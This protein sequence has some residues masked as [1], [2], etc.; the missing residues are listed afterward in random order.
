M[1]RVSIYWMRRDLRLED[2]T[3]LSKA[4]HS[5]DPVLPLF[6]F[7]QNILEELP[8]DDARITFIHQQLESIQDTLKKKHN[9][10]LLVQYGKPEKIFQAL[11]NEF[12]ITGVFTNRDYEPYAK[13]RDSEIR[14]LLEAKK[15]P[16]YDFKD[17]VIFEKDEVQSGSGEV[18][19][20]FTPYS[21]KWLEKLKED[22]S[23]LAE[24]THPSNFHSFNS[25]LPALP[26]MGFKPSTQEFPPLHIDEELISRYAKNRDFPALDGTS[27]LGI[28]LRFG[29]VSIR[30]LVKKARELDKTFLNELI[31]REF[32]M[33]ILDAYPQVV[34]NAFKP[35][36]DNINWRNNEE[37][38]RL[39][40]E[41]KTGYPLVDAGM[42]QMNE[43]G[44]M[45][46]RVRMVTASF[47]SKHL[48]IDWRW[49][50]A[51]FA[52]KLL[53]YELS[54]NNGGWQWAAG[55]GTDA[56]P[57][58]RIFNPESQLKKFDK[59]LAYVKKWVPE[60]GS[61]DYP[62]PM[63]EHSFARERALE[64]FKKAVKK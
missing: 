36:Y 54:S 25:G 42:R 37:E 29:T 35:Q 14:K 55:S 43:I 16:F 64:E 3:A 17:Q 44:Y 45:H 39:W 10:C 53:D 9:S 60:Y 61:K 8:E 20:V 6:I 30:K 15:I 11:I 58:F 4:L 23:G 19:K 12:E 38:F 22:E 46:N 41:G 40:C 33:M 34:E 50:E 51:Y 56:Q 47:L 1:K 49:G 24:R 63:V 2:N 52:E 26:E 48:L 59:D 27:R 57:Y 7:D 5:A 62:E 21:R 13:E 31:W 18:Y 32:Y 28:H